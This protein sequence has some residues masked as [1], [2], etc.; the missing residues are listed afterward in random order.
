MPSIQLSFPN[1]PGSAAGEIP[2][3]S[4]P[5]GP[6][7][8]HEQ[9]SESSP[10][11]SQN[12][13]DSNSFSIPQPRQPN[14][15]YVT[16]FS[17]LEGW[18]G[19]APLAPFNAG[20]QIDLGPPFYMAAARA[21]P[22]ASSSSSPITPPFQIH[23]DH[24]QQPSPIPQPLIGH[25]S[26]NLDIGWAYDASIIEF[27]ASDS[28]QSTHRNLSHNRSEVPCSPSSV[29]NLTGHI[30]GLAID[31]TGPQYDYR[32]RSVSLDSAVNNQSHIMNHSLIQQRSQQHFKSH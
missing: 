24:S 7:F 5:L 19:M 1:V 11:F 12:N 31:E 2:F 14:P 21:D 6:P 8:S 13:A 30:T 3:A 9:P 16:S 4:G 25:A 22:I 32:Q 23:P 10:F 18:D 17:S 15:T 28:D 20:N 27:G 26:E 29:R